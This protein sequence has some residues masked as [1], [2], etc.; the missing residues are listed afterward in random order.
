MAEKNTPIRNAPTLPII[1]KIG[2]AISGLFAI[3]G[4]SAAERYRRAP[5][6]P[7]NKINDLNWVFR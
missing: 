6:I 3:D 5:K 1:M 4:S 2:F 7:M